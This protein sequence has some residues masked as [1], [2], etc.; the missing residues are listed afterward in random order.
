[1]DDVMANMK[2]LDD[3]E[4]EIQEVVGAKTFDY[5]FCLVGRCLTDSVVHFPSLRNTMADLWHP[6]GGICITELREKR[7]LF[8]FF[9]K[10]D[11]ERVTAGTPWFFNNHLL[12]LQSILEGENSA[13]MDLKFTEF[14]IQV[15]DLPLGLMNELMAKQ[16]GNSNQGNLSYEG[17]VLGRNVRGAI[18]SQNINPNLRQ[19]GL[20]KYEDNSSYTSGYVGGDV[21]MVTDGVGYGPMNLVSNE[22]EDPIAMLEGKKRQ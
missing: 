12:I 20:G 15:H 10:I 17:K 7:Y 8:Q 16:F 5:Q 21:R 14:W 3:E 9:N 11:F 2:L 1:M 4:E 22:E 18:G 13:V 6:I 19:S